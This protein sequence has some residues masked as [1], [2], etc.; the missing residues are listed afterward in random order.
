MLLYNCWGETLHEIH[1]GFSEQ[2]EII[3]EKNS[4]PFHFDLNGKLVFWEK[5]DSTF[6]WKAINN[7]CA[8]NTN[9]AGGNVQAMYILIFEAVEESTQV[10]VC[11]AVKNILFFFLLP[12]APQKPDE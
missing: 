4:N 8:T 11:I 10:A 1:T 6:C 9:L 5:L 3:I 12:A 2:L 7:V